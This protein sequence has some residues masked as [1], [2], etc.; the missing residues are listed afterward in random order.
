M[1]RTSSIQVGDLP[2]E[3]ARERAAGGTP[4][5][6]RQRALRTAWPLILLFA[7]SLPAVTPR[8]YASDEV[9]YFVF[10]RSAWFDH[11]LSFDNDYRYFY[12]H[13]IAASEGFHQTHLEMTT[14]TGRR[15][16]YGTVGPAILWAPFYGVAD[17]L[18]RVGAVAGPRDGFS[19]PYI[20]AVCYGS[21]FYTLLALLLSAAAA[22]QMVDGRAGAVSAVTI[23]SLVVFAGTPLV[24]YSHVAPVFAH[25]C[26]AFAVALFVFTW[27]R[28]RRAWRARGLIALGAAAALMTMVREQDVFFIVGP[29]IDFAL[30]LRAPDRAREGG[31][32]GDAVGT[33]SRSRLLANAS[34]ACAAFAIAWLPQALAYLTLNGRL[35]PSHL[36]SRKMAWTSPHALQVLAS[37]ENGLLFWTPLV[38]LCLAGLLLLATDRAPAHRRAI[39]CMLAMFAAQAYISGSVQSWRVAGAFGQRRFVGVTVLLVIGLA[40]I[41]VRARSKASRALVA[42]LL[43][44]CTW[45]N[46]ALIVQFATGQMDRQ[47][48]T[49]GANAY[50]TFVVVPRELPRIVYRYAFDRKSFYA[51][52]P[53]GVRRPVE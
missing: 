46:V 17:I 4:L 9:Q 19:H 38:L 47:R 29:A 13:G 1:N 53:G 27:L 35:G 18:V 21:A 6:R 8:I 48:L 39:A 33:P 12:E 15:L 44:A 50:N 14:E 42:V 25:A 30:A 16:N 36:V 10:L 40:T 43:A 52:P 51:A 49:L 23:S 28:V 24:F 5:R 2:P 11:D 3:D 41:L 34:A 22:R 32:A 26:S 7:V 20:A 45:W 37:P 31:P